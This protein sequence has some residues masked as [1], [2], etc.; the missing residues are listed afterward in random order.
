MSF[1]D[2]SLLSFG[3]VCRV[4]RIVKRAYDPRRD[5]ISDQPTG[6]ASGTQDNSSHA[7]DLLAIPVCKS[8][9]E[10][11]GCPMGECEIKREERYEPAPQQAHAW[12]EQVNE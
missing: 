8:G 10:P 12:L 6:A 11:H 7:S 3:F 2:A 9:W 1:F 4:E 5:N